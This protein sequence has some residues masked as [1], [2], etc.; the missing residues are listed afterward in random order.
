M[1]VFTCVLWGKQSQNIALIFQIL[2][3][4]TI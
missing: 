2:T 4:I 3:I 1:H